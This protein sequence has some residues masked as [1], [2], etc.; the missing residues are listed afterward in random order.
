MFKR[1]LLFLIVLLL[2]FL[3]F[4]I[5]NEVSVLSLF[6]KG[7]YKKGDDVSY[8]E[9][10]G[11]YLMVN[12]IGVD[13]KG[14]ELLFF[15]YV[16]F[17]IKFGIIFIKEKIEYYVEWVL[18]VIVYKEFRVVELDLSVKIEVIYYDKNKKKEEMKFFFIIEKGFVV[19]DLLEYIKNF[20]FNLII[21]V[22]IEK[23]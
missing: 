1:S 15:Y 6:D 4:L 17:F 8:F 3:F 9:L 21:K 5:I 20:G 16:E 19:L 18:D 12:V 7:K 22:V 2:L 14:N 10:I 13:G 23:K 11:L